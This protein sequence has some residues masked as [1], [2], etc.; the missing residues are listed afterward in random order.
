MWGRSPPLSAVRPAFP[1]LAPDAVQRIVDAAVN[2]HVAERC[3]PS[4]LL[5]EIQSADASARGTYGAS[6]SLCTH[7]ADLHVLL[8]TGRTYE[9]RA[10]WPGARCMSSSVTSRRV[11]LSTALRSMS[12]CE[13]PGRV[14]GTEDADIVVSCSRSYVGG[15]AQ[16]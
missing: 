8:V 4:E 3:P 10:G 11:K 5:T 15:G 9:G 1:D 2:V 14:H 7:D 13:F 16:V 6:F 12:R